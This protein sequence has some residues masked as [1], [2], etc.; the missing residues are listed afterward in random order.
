MFA[1]SLQNGVCVIAADNQRSII[2]T[3]NRVLRQAISLSLLLSH[4]HTQKSTPKRQ[5]AKGKNSIQGQEP[6]LEKR[7]IKTTF[8]DVTVLFF[9]AEVSS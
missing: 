1:W 4:T 2:M 5:Q 6:Y 3:R 7:K 8:P 9:L